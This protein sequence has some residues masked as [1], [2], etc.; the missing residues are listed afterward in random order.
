MSGLFARLGR[1]LEIVRIE[2]SDSW[3][4]DARRAHRLF[5]APAFGAVALVAVWAVNQRIYIRI[6]GEDAVL[7]WFQV[8]CFLA[9][10]L[11]GS[12]I[13]LDLLR[14][15]RTLDAAFFFAFAAAFFFIAGEE[16]AWAQRILGLETPAGF[17][18]RNVQGET[19]IHNL[20]GVRVFFHVGVLLLALFGAVAPW[21]ARARDRSPTIKRLRPAIPPLFLTSFFLLAFLGQLQHSVVAPLVGDITILKF[22][23][24][25]ETCLAAGI[26]AYALL[27]RR[28]LVDR[29]GRQAVVRLRAHKSGVPG[30]PL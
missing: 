16:I 2:A 20:S 27:T 10:A 23:E 26:V 6:A 8:G 22:S 14:R 29:P 4:V 7:E 1:I 19:T 28:V 30:S 11:A 9:A 24:Y 25:W 18:A 5:L 12:L 15:K 13:G 3:Q 21:V 17:A